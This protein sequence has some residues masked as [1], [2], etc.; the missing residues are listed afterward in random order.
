M[1]R[2][3]KQTEILS[4]GKQKETRK[5]IDQSILEQIDQP[6]FENKEQVESQIAIETFETT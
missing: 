5:R 1:K 4:I 2:R 6:I 3:K